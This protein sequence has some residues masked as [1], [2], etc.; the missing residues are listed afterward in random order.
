MR[1]TDDRG[2]KGGRWA[3]VLA[4]GEGT[5]LAHLTRG[6]DGIATP[7]QFC[8]I[9]GGPTL[10]EQTVRRA[11]AVVGDRKVVTVVAAAH[12]RWWERDLDSLPRE[13]VV[14]QPM[15]RGTAAG[16][17]LPLL[18]IAERDPGATVLVLP[19]DHGVEDETVLRRSMADALDDCERDSEHLVLLGISGDSPDP[20]LGWIVPAERGGRCVP[21]ARFVE[22][23]TVAEADRLLRGG[24]MWNSFIFAA[25]ISTLVAICRSALPE[26]WRPLRWARVWDRRHPGAGGALSH[27]YRH[28]PAQDF[29]RDVLSARPDSLRVLRVPPC[30]WSDLGTPE[31]LRRY[32]AS[33][34]P[35]AAI[36]TLRPA[37]ALAVASAQ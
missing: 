32:A 36:P 27:V 7:K 1:A 6:G 17:L 31:R 8:S 33:E 15:N 16:I 28:L 24:A 12:R 19:S 9:A 34:I 23:P 5:R 22:K 30:G 14:V 11:A 37:L 13:N 29:S 25:R 10:L 26:L 20:D 3:L 18:A 2:G 21:V 4:A 35:R